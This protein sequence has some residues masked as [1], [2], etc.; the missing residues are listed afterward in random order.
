[1]T[2]LSGFSSHHANFDREFT[3]IIEKR[4]LR[5]NLKQQNLISGHYELNPC[6]DTTILV[7]TTSQNSK[8]RILYHNCHN[9]D[10]TA[11]QDHFKVFR[12]SKNN[13]LGNFSLIA[14]HKWN[15]SLFFHGKQQLL[16]RLLITSIGQVLLKFGN[17]LLSATDD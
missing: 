2:Y 7:K 12:L 14:N 3:M 4:E 15:F 13:F 5:K 6:F 1:M 17:Q 10:F 11:S 9:I 8:T 16:A